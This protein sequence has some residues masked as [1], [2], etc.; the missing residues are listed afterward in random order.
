MG[1]DVLDEL[2]GAGEVEAVADALIQ[3]GADIHNVPHL[4]GA[5]RHDG[6]G[7]VHGADGDHNG[8]GAVVVQVMVHGG[9]LNAAQVGDEHRGV[10]GVA[11]REDPGHLAPVVQPAHHTHDE[12][13]QQPWQLG[14]FVHDVVQTYSV[15]LLPHL[16]HFA[17]DAAA[18]V[19]QRVA[20]FG[21]VDHQGLFAV[22]GEAALGDEADGDF[23]PLVNAHM[24]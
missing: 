5:V 7:L 18:D 10:V 17:H 11:L 9:A 13:Q 15:L 16:M 1:T 3:R 2:Q 19:G 20:A 21:L 8:V 6:R 23:I 22:V 24:R 14:E 12:H 4:N